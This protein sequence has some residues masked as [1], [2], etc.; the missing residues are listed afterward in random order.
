MAPPVVPDTT[1]EAETQEPVEPLFTADN[2]DADVIAGFLKSYTDNAPAIKPEETVQGQLESVL[3]K[4][5]AL[6]D[7]ARGQAAQYS[8]SRGLINSDMAAEA[9]AQAVMGVALP[10][11]Q[12]DAQVY[13]NRAAQER[14][15][16]LTAGLQAFDATIQSGLIAQDHMSNLVEMSH[17][18]DINSRL[19]L[20]QFGY[21][22]N[23]NEQQNFHNMQLS[24]L[25]GDIQAG[26]A[27]QAFGFDTELMSRDFGYQTKLLEHGL[28]NALA[29]SKQDNEQW[30]ERMGVQHVYTLD[31]IAAQ[32][33]ITSEQSAQDFSQNMR[34]Q[35]LAK[36]GDAGSALSVR[37]HEIN[38]D[39]GLT[40]LQ[41][42]NA[43]RQAVLD[44]EAE[45]D[46]LEA[47]YIAT[48]GWD[49]SWLVDPINTP[50]S[51]E[52]G[53]TGGDTGDT[54][55]DTVIDPEPDPE[56]EL[57]PEPAPPPSFEDD[58]EEFWE[59]LPD[60]KRDL[61]DPEGRD[62]LRDAFD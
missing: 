42:H 33:D 38:T 44:Y 28:R 9:S 20:E 31:E 49:L 52:G 23:L 10:I 46:R 58:P 6:F 39:D 62:F 51:H 17:Q 26:L 48:P 50:H 45:M 18:G 37:L 55:S 25:Q 36:V 29:L 22:W 57:E 3:N 32:G 13:A 2:M 43:E 11:A 21:N 56:L 59:Q 7:W 35:Y 4:D 40:L 61:F 47:H 54:G 30:I 19:Q 16:W 27:L 53:H 34:G 24:L 1:Q 60:Y 14:E 12:A 41:Q 15:F 5:N 8:N